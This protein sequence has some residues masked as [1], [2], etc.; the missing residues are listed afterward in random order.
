MAGLYALVVVRSCLSCRALPARSTARR[1]GVVAV[2]AVVLAGCGQSSTSSQ[3]SSTPAATSSTT[4]TTSAAGPPPKPSPQLAAAERPRRDGFPAAGGRTPRQLASLARSSVTLGAAT[5][6]FTPGA[7]RYAFGLTTTSGRFLYEPTAL[8]LASTPDSPA[9]GPYLAPADP[10]GVAPQY[11]SA[12]NAGPGG[13]EAIYHA[14]LPLPRA[15]TYALLALTRTPTGL[16]GAPGEVAVAASSPIPGVGQR[17][18]AIDTDTAASVHG[19]TALLTTRQPPEHMASASLD[20]V[21]GRR[22]VALLF[23]TPQLCTS[24]VC[25]PVTDVTVSLQKQFPA[26]TFIHQEVYVDNDP[27]K[28]LRPQ[29]QAFHLRTEPWLFAINRRGVIVARLEGAFGVNELRSALRAAER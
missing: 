27:E 14:T 15:G 17:P 20:Q 18:P 11:R 21:L 4:A 9:S 8:Y 6:T 29:L 16:V 26:V 2:A 12:Q 10:M 25:G 22:P 28:G 24:R 1:A 23:S 19:D 7:G 3:S 13:I 5:G